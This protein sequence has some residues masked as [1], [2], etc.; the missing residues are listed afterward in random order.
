MHI[1]GQSLE[2]CLSELEN[3]CK[4]ESQYTVWSAIVE[5]HS[6]HRMINVFIRII[7]LKFFKFSEFLLHSLSNISLLLFN[8]V[9]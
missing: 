7:C 3:S 9:S 8:F 1:P 6:I 5:E 4:S 2:G